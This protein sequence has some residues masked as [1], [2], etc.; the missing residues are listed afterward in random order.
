MQWVLQNYTTIWTWALPQLQSVQTLDT[1]ISLLLA[2]MGDRS[3]WYIF[4]WKEKKQNIAKSKTSALQNCKRR[5]MVRSKPWQHLL[6]PVDF[7]SPSRGKLS[8]ATPGSACEEGPLSR[9]PCSVLPATASLPGICSSPIFQEHFEYFPLSGNSVSLNPNRGLRLPNFFLKKFSS[10]K[11]FF[12]LI[13]L[14]FRT[15]FR[16]T[17]NGANDTENSYIY[18]PPTHISYIS[19]ISH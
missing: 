16:F 7:L 4:L 15:V 5:F 18:V 10:F 8:P 6:P 1:S 12:Q 9:T 2:G 3:Q 11:F 14:I 19:N 13:A 17:E